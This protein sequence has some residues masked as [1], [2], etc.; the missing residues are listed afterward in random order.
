MRARVIAALVIFTT[1]IIRA[2]EYRVRGETVYDGV[3]NNGAM[4]GQGCLLLDTGETWVGQFC[5]V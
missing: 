3:F 5:K 2:G 4:H 1:I